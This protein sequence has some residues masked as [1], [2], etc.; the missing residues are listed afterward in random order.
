MPTYRPS[1]WEPGPTNGEWLVMLGIPALAALGV[2]FVL[3]LERIG[4]L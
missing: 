2:L 3:F 4:Q 1:D